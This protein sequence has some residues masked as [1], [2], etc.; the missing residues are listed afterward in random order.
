[1]ID[2][3]ISCFGVD[4]WAKFNTFTNLFILFISLSWAI[5]L[6]FKPV[7]WWQKSYLMPL[8]FY[9]CSISATKHFKPPIDAMYVLWELSMRASWVLLFSIHIYFIHGGGL[10]LLHFL[11]G[12]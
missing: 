2:W 6:S 1:M 11:V 3:G 9:V 7:K 10:P 12:Q 8:N 4:S 5:E